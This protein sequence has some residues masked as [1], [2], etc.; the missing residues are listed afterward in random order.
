MMISCPCCGPRSFSEFSYG[1]DATVA[2][3]AD[4]STDGDAWCRYVYAR[5]NP[6]GAHLELWQHTG[7]CRAWLR[8]ERDTA[9]HAISRVALL[10][11]W[12]DEAKPLPE[13]AE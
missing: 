1:G 6:K 3:P 13:A 7:G 12:A 8:V 9:T 2:R 10:G 4:G 5:A 11:A